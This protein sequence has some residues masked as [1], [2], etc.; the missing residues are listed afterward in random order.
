MPKLLIAEEFDAEET[1]VGCHPPHGQYTNVNIL[2][3]R[4]YTEDAEVKKVLS[5]YGEIN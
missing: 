3:L 5:Q 4:S 2:N 1:H